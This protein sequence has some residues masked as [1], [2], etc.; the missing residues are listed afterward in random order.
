MLWLI[1]MAWS[2]GETSYFGWNMF[3][4]SDAELMADGLACLLF[5][6]AYFGRKTVV[7]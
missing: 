5:A 3:P 2:I 4:K 1:A 6:L 7:I